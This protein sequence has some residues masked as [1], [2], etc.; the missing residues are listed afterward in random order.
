MINLC[1]LLPSSLS[2]SSQSRP[3]CRHVAVS[4]LG[5]VEAGRAQVGRWRYT[6]SRARLVKPAPTRAAL[7]GSQ[8]CR[9]Q[10]F[11][12]NTGWSNILKVAGRMAMIRSSLLPACNFHWRGC[13]LP[14]AFLIC[15]CFILF[16][17]GD[18]WTIIKKCLQK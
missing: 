1:C 6:W 4:R 7:G 15:C 8:L 11:Q 18:L 16:N 12:I 13:K 17:T 9:F 3:F 5:Q 10:P 2:H 14:A